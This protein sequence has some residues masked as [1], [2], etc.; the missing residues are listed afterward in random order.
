M[1]LEFIES[2]V[3]PESENFIA[4]HGGAQLIIPAA[5]P[6]ST[7]TFTVSPPSSTYAIICF[8]VI[9]GA[10]VVP[11]AFACSIVH[12]GRYIYNGTLSGAV[13]NFG[14]DFYLVATTPNPMTVIAIN[15][16]A[17]AQYFEMIYQF[18]LISTVDDYNFILESL[19]SPGNS[20]KEL[21]KIRE[22]LEA[23]KK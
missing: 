9:F 4:E 3:R 10:A 8:K 7:T 20:L 22:V 16:H 11:S 12:N 5:A 6:G 19:R 18:F 21:V 13:I 14:I 1:A 15:N 2:L 17:L 23:A